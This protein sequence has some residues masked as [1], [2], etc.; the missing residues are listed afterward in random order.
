MVDGTTISPEPGNALIL[1][2]VRAANTGES[3]VD[4]PSR[5]SLA[6]IT[7]GS[8]YQPLKPK[9]KPGGEPTLSFPLGGELYETVED[10]HPNVTAL[11]WVF[12][13]VPADSMD[14]RISLSDSQSSTLEAYW[15]GQVDPSSLPD[16]E[17]TSLDVPEEH[18]NGEPIQFSVSVTNTG[19]SAGLF[20]QRFSV[21]RSTEQYA[22]GGTL[23]TTIEPGETVTIEKTL[24][25]KGVQDITISVPSAIEKTVRVV[26]TKAQFGSSH[27]LPNGVQLRVSEPIVCDT[28]RVDQGGGSFEHRSIDRRSFAVFE[29]TAWNPTDSTI[30]ESVTGGFEVEANGYV[31]SNSREYPVGLLDPVEKPFFRE[32]YELAPEETMNGVLYFDVPKNTQ[33][34]EVIFRAKSPVTERANKVCEWKIGE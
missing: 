5:D 22:Q 8:Q 20:N 4:L 16:M 7:G 18:V 9:G 34:D 24:P 26:P 11:G 21:V 27:E 3:V 6:L 19:G 32:W 10:A 14:F 12:F 33:A 17:I 13:E 1:A 30:S 29:I 23:D 15:E 25:A 31:D 2:D 28:V